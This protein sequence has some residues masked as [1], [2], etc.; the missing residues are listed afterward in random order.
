MTRARH[1][2]DRTTEWTQG[3]AVLSYDLGGKKVAGVGVLVVLLEVLLLLASLAC[4]ALAR[5]VLPFA[6]TRL[7]DLLVFPVVLAVVLACSDRWPP[8]CR[9]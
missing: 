3:S 4:V 7:L 8:R 9:R 1:A 6:L 5:A 2:D